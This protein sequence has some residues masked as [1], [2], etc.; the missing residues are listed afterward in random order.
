MTMLLEAAE[1]EGIDWI[2][3]A[4]YKEG[5]EKIN[6]IDSVEW[7]AKT[8]RSNLPT[9]LSRL[10]RRRV[11]MCGATVPKI[12]GVH[13]RDWC[14]WDQLLGPFSCGERELEFDFCVIPHPS[15]RCREYN[16]PETRAEVGDLLLAEFLRWKNEATLERSKLVNSRRL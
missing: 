2:S 6:L 4:D 16:S 1:R 13:W 14:E 5:F 15:G 11:V 9:V 8:A 12:V 3:P 10:N 7:S